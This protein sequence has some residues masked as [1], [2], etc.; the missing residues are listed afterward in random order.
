[1]IPYI[2][3]AVVTALYTGVIVYMIERNARERAEWL[4]ALCAKEE[5]KVISRPD[6][7]AKETAYARSLRKWRHP[8]D[9]E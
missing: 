9:P 8:N 6:I 2:V 7:K 5:I 3:I 4:K 1:M